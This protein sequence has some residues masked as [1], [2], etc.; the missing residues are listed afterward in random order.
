MSEQGNDPIASVTPEAFA[1]LVATATDGEVAELVH[2]VGTEEVL[3]R[4]F[5]GMRARFRPDKARGVDAVIQFVITDDGASHHY[6]VTIRNEDCT[7]GRGRAEN[8]KVTLT[9]DLVSFVKLI[10]GRAEGVQ[11]FMTGKLKATGDVMFSARLT[12]FF[13]RPQ[14]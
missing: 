2:A 7:T 9:M 13:D 3:D 6:L 14:A 4:I 12:S 1:Q 5:D 10:T 8:A 11:L